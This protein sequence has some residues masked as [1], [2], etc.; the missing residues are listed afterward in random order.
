VVL[1]MPKHGSNVHAAQT[2][3]RHE[4]EGVV[5]ATGKFD[6]E[7]NELR[8]V[9]LDTAFNLYSEAGSGFADHVFHVFTQQ[10]P[11]LANHWRSRG[12]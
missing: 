2:L 6:D 10:R 9:G 5:A 12:E 11:D 8:D 7:V 1:A 3:K 4:F